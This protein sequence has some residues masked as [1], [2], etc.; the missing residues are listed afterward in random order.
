MGTDRD[1]RTNAHSEI[2][3]A[4]KELPSISVCS[5]MHTCLLFTQCIASEKAGYKLY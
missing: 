1:A 2:C 4:A 3:N 5:H